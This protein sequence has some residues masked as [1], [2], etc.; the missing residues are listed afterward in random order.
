M[1]EIQKD[2][3]VNNLRG[4]QELTYSDHDRLEMLR[5]MVSSSDPSG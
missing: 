4:S 1:F 5:E 2:H 3:L